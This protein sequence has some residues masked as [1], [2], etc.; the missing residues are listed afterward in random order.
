MDPVA[1]TVWRFT[2]GRRGH[3]TQ[4]L[5][6]TQA[7]ARLHP[8]SLFD[9]PIPP[10]IHALLDL[11]LRRCPAGAALPDPDLLVGAGHATHLP[12]ISA[13]RAR[14]GRAVILM[15]P[16]LPMACFDLCLIPSHDAPPDRPNIIRTQGPLNTIVCDDRPRTGPGLILI[17]GPSKHYD[18]RHDWLLERLRGLLAASAESWIISDSPRTPAGTRSALAG[19]AGGN[20]NY[21]PWDRAGHE[22]LAQRLPKTPVAWITCDSLS[23]IYEALTAGCV[24]G[25]LELP[26]RR[27]SHVTRAIEELIFDSM[28]TPVSAWR[29]GQPLKT[30]RRKLDEASRCA[31]IVLEWYAKAP[32]R[33]RTT[34]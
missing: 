34:T 23:M 5:G 8:C 20:V 26:A 25:V 31:A 28:V 27:T 24:V 33:G 4:S 13:R 7:L 9:L 21:S 30:S 10:L 29:A 18:W 11:I 22:W 15:T 17:G 32:A 12:L 2:D 3:D 6:L 1:L 14:G 16:S 19:L